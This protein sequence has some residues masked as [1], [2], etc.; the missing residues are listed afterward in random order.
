MAFIVNCYDLLIKNGTVIDP[1][2]GINGK[3]DIGIYASKIGD[4]FEPGTKP[5]KICG[6]KVID[7]TGKYVVPAW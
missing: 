5:G 1:A 7:A 4:V 2:N 6:R 3:R